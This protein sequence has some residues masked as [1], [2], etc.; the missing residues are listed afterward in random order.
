MVGGSSELPEPHMARTRLINPA[1]TLDEDVASM[2]LAARYV[3]AYLPC[4]AD[5]EGRLKDSAFSLKAE[6]MPGDLDIDMNAILSELAA[7][8]HIVRY[9]SS[10][11]RY[12]QIRN[13]DKYQT[14]HPRESSSVIPPMYA[15]DVPR[16]DLGQAKALLSG[17]GSGSGSGERSGSGEGD[18]DQSAKEELPPPP[19]PL[20]T[21]GLI[22]LV[23]IAVGERR[24]NLG[25]YTPGRWAASSAQTF[26]DAIPPDRRTDATRNEIRAKVSAFAESDDPRITKGKWSVEAFCEGYNAI[27]VPKPARKKTSLELAQEAEVASW[28]GR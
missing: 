21:A 9:E 6:I 10:G 19:D 25:L 13:F 28:N 24:P 27:G 16:T 22:L 2:S 15:L 14:P 20:T 11:K 8:K 17:S 7:Q 4:Y 5:R 1:A 18:P 26:L 23:K 3:W 12:I